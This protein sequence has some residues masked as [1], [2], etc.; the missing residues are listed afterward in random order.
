[1]K[2]VKAFIRCAV[3]IRNIDVDAA[4]DNDILVCRCSAGYADAVAGMRTRKENKEYNT[5][6]TAGVFGPGVSL[7]RVFALQPPFEL[8]HHAF[9][10]D[11]KYSYVGDDRRR[12][13]LLL[14]PRGCSSPLAVSAS[15]FLRI[16][17]ISIH[18]F[19]NRG[20]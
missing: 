14:W 2:G 7:K 8:A 4:S 9:A 11:N 13:E 6:R 19:S 15:L 10:L 5:P 17:S 20:G 18:T 12:C 1:L 3:D 16:L